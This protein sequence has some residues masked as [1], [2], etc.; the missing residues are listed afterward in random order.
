[1]PVYQGSRFLASSLASVLNQSF[2]DFELIVVDDQ[3][4]DDTYDIAQRVCGTADGVECRVLRNTTRQGLFG[5]WNRCVEQCRGKYILLFHQDD[6]MEQGMLE[7]AIAAFERH[8]DVGLV[9]CGYRCVDDSGA[10]LPP[11][12][13]SPFVGRAGREEFLRSLV[14]E[15][16]VCC[17]SVIVPRHVY[18]RVGLYDTRFAFTGDLEMW[19]RIA[20]FYDVFYEPMVG[21]RYRLHDAQATEEFR[22]ERSGRAELEHIVAV[23]AGL[24]RQRTAFPEL[25]RTVVRDTVWTIRQQARV[26][27]GDA[28]WALRMIGSRPLDVAFA[29]GDVLV[30]KIGRRLGRVRVGT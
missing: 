11:W 4:T 9:Y 27:P 15:N 23:F 18:D 21:V 14:A 12:S 20:S 16:F 3:S 30:R 10:D 25:W 24:E 28:R 17:P 5:N 1:M 6:L 13:V 26:A 7:R 8:R 22:K 2:R 29:C 19:V